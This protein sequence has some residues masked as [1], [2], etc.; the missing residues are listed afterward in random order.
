MKTQIIRHGEVILKEDTLPDGAEL[1]KTTNEY[2]VAHSETGHDHVVTAKSPFKVYNHNGTFYMELTKEGE[3]I[4]RK[5]GKDAHKTHKIKPS[6]FKVIIKKSF[7][8]FS[9]LMERV[10]D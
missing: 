3:L 2:V 8:Y 9:G 4:H 1:V 6:V 7:N 5:T 10:R